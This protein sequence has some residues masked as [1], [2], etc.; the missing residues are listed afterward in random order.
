[1]CWSPELA[2]ASPLMLPKFYSFCVDI[3]AVGQ[4]LDHFLAHQ[5]GPEDF[6]RSRIQGLIRSGFVR[7]GGEICKSGYPLQ[8]GAEITIDLPPAVSSE[9][10]P[11]Q[12]HFRII[13]EDEELIVI[14]KPPG[15]VVH[16]SCGHSSGTLVH[17]LLYHCKNLSGISGEQ[18]PGIV[19]R[20]DKDTSGIMVV[21]KN[22][23]THRAL[24]EQF[25]GRQ[26]QKIYHAILSG[27]P[28]NQAGRVAL[29]IGRHPVNRQKMA[30]REQGGRQAVTCW[31]IIEKFACPYI[32]VEVKLETG[33][34]HQIRVHMA[35]QGLPVAGDALYGG[36]RGDAAYWGIERQ[37]L[38]SSQLE[39]VHPKTNE[40]LRFVAPLWPDFA[41][42]LSKMRGSET[43]TR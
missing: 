22:D 31:K 8:M 30:V 26:V 28:V 6:S 11:E 14:A 12:V 16:P 41:E 36:I 35:A 1:M 21:A 32:Y 34:T 2:H 25:K 27:H 13:Y 18:R 24:I 33:R 3:E 39:F 43:V 9:L 42:V 38:H 4:R 23:Q 40:Q 37:C 15:V 5:L 19:H 29:P 10:I 7:V 17:G 20:L